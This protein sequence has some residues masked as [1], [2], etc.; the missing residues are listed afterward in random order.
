[1]SNSSNT[2]YKEEN[3]MRKRNEKKQHMYVT[4]VRYTKEK[5][6]LNY[7]QEELGLVPDK[8]ILAREP[9]G[10]YVSY[11]LDITPDVHR[12]REELTSG[13]SRFF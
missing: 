11:V 7:L 1:M 6:F 8:V 9:L 13:Q 3:E 5:F 10:G 2:I 12:L 4:T